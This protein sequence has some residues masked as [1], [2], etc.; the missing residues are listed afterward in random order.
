MTDTDFTVE[1]ETY[2]AVDMATSP[3]INEHNDNQMSS[4]ESNYLIIDTSNSSDDTEPVVKKKQR[5]DDDNNNNNEQ[6]KSSK[7]IEP[8]SKFTFS[9]FGE[10]PSAA[11]ATDEDTRY[12]Y[13]KFESDND[14]MKYTKCVSNIS[15]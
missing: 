11:A 8:K 7:N 12:E 3:V 10:K 13:M 6:I 15:V 14:E 5:I 1:R 9:L 2:T 4:S